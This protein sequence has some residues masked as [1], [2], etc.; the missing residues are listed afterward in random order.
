M[1]MSP[2]AFSK[3]GW[4][5]TGATMLSGP[6]A[7]LVARTRS[8]QPLTASRMLSVPPV[9]MMPLEPAGAWNRSSPMSSTSSS[10]RLRPKKARRPPSAF[11]LMNFVKASLP[12]RS[13]CSPAKKV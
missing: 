1:S 2:P 9:V 3:A 6:A 10:M 4:A 12:T 11:S 5:L 7:P 8:R 13:T